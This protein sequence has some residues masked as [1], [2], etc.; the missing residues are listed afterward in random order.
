MGLDLVEL[1]MNVEERFGIEIS[2]RE[3]QVCTTPRK[4]AD[5]IVQKVHCSS[6]SVCLSQRAFHLLRRA[7]LNVLGLPRPQF[8]LDTRLEDVVPSEGR[9]RVWLRLGEQTGALHWPHL[10]RPRALLRILVALTLAAF[11]IPFFYLNFPFHSLNA[12]AAF[13]AIAS[14]I[15]VAWVGSIATRPLMTAFPPGYSTVKDLVRF[16]IAGNVEL[17][18]ADDKN[19]TREEVRCVLRDIIIETLQVRDFTEDSH[20]VKD[21]KV[22]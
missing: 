1:V 3:A 21:M 19:W 9:R 13:A 4:L 20:F 12:L 5:L 18:K 11:L 10:I 14:C 16:I 7:S 22:D 6:R 8:R 2:D 17:V 15:T